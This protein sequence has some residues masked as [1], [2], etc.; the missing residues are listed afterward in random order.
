[1]CDGIQ[2]QLR[3]SIRFESRSIY[4]HRHAYAFIN[5][6]RRAWIV[7]SIAYFEYSLICWMMI[8]EERDGTNNLVRF[9]HRFNYLL[10]CSSWCKYST[11]TALIALM[12]F[13][14]IIQTPP[15]DDVARGQFQ[16]MFF[17]MNIS[18]AFFGFIL[19]SF[20]YFFTV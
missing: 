10:N 6:K 17:S 18:F 7:Y 9:I 4:K 13:T 16:F 11:Q 20:F 12:F 15:I 5:R 19:K 2:V 3:T 8:P 14:F 1:M